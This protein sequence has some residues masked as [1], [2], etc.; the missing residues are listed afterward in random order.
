MMPAPLSKPQRQ[1][2]CP[3]KRLPVERQY[4]PRVPVDAVDVQVETSVAQREG[5][6]VPAIISDVHGKGLR[7]DCLRLPVLKAKFLSTTA[8]LYFQHPKW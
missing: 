6:L 1:I 2:L 7:E 3:S 4:G 8:A 5:N